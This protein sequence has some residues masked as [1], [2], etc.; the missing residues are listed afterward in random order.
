[1]GNRAA[2]ELRRGAVGGESVVRTRHVQGRPA[3]RSA[4]RSLSARL[5]DAGDHRKVRDG[6]AILHSGSEQHDRPSV[7]GQAVEPGVEDVGDV[8]RDAYIA[9]FD[10]RGDL[11]G[12]EG[13]ASRGGGDRLERTRSQRPAHGALGDT[14]ECK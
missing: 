12:E 11:L 5:L 10:R 2:G 9:I 1:M 3:Q 6:E 14:G 4:D 8:L 7:L 13:I